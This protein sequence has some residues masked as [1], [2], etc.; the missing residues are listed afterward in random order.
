VGF[1][2]TFLLLLSFILLCR[3]N[4]GTGSTPLHIPNLGFPLILRELLLG[5][6]HREVIEL[7]ARLNL[8]DS[9]LLALPRL[10]RGFKRGQWFLGGVAPS[11]RREA[12]A[13]VGVSLLFLLGAKAVYLLTRAETHRR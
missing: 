13:F 12:L 4:R 8:L 2:S 6:H 9:V 7:V 1:G 11:K 5:V 10:L 3:P